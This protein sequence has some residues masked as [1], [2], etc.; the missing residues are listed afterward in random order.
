MSYYCEYCGSKSHSVASL[1]ASTCPLH[2]SGS[3]KG[4]HKLYEGG[5][6]SRYT[7]KYCGSI[8]SGIA[9]LV[10][11]TCIRHPNKGGKHSPAL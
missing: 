2:P 1:V 11:A 3:H 8:S 7:C 4:R 10:R 5:E 6:K 9:S